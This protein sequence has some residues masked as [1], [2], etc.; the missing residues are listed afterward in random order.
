MELKGVSKA[1]ESNLLV[2]AGIQVKAPPMTDYNFLLDASSVGAL[3]NSQGHGFPCHTALTVKKFF[4]DIQ[5]K[6]GFL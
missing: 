5:L 6:S 2:H 4:S 3:A 1:I